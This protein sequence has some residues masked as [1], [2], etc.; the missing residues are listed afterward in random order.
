MT[1]GAF[2]NGFLWGVATSANGRGPADIDGL[3][4]QGGWTHRSTV[5]AYLG[6]AQ[7]D[8]APGPQSWR[9]ALVASHHL[10]LSHGRAVPVIR[11]NSPRAK[12]GITLNASEVEPASPNEA[13]RR[14]ARQFDHAHDNFEW[15]FGF[16][17]RFGIVWVDLH[18]QQRIAKA[19]GHMYRR[20]IKGN[21]LP[22]SHAA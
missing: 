17:K 7:G 21:E 13:D 1:A 6:Y 3:Q 22:E 9:E 19:S 18:S 5:D 8:Q 10:L 12:V 20:I 16:S 11:C 15:A 14:S 4:D 2:P